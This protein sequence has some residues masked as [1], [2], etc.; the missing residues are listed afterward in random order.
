[1]CYEVCGVHRGYK[2]ADNTP[3]EFIYYLQPLRDNEG[4]KGNSFFFNK[5]TNVKVGD[6]ISPICKLSQ[7]GKP[8]VVD[9]EILD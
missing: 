5:H 2:K 8:Y 4:V 1:M 6:M 7:T 3:F 9:I